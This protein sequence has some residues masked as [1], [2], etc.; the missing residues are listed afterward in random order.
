MAHIWRFL[1]TMPFGRRAR[2]IE[3]LSAQRLFLPSVSGKVLQLR[4]LPSQLPLSYRMHVVLFYMLGARPSRATC[5]AQHD[6]FSAGCAG[7]V[8]QANKQMLADRAFDIAPPCRKIGRP[9][10]AWGFPLRAA[11]RH[12]I[13]YPRALSAEPYS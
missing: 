1:A 6:V 12:T 8:A 4:R 5:C 2:G 13:A 9:A 11:E 3:V 7:S 10:A